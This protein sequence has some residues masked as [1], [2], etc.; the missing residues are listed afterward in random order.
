MGPFSGGSFKLR[1]RENGRRSRS[2]QLGSK[3]AR[4]TQVWKL[5]DTL[6]QVLE[7]VVSTRLGV[8]ASVTSTIDKGT[9]C[10]I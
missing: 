6:A 1:D 7:R 2:L 4:I 3:R 9:R 5:P 10:V 8:T